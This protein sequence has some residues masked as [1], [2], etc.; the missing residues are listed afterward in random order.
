MSEA[1]EKPA[2]QGGAEYGEAQIR[3]LEGIE[4]IRTRPAM[5][6][7]DTGTRGFHHLVYEVVDNSVDEAVN[8]H[9]SKISVKINADGSVTCRDDGRGIPVGP[10]KDVDN[11]PAVE[12]VLTHIHAGGKFD[13]DSGYKTGTGGLHG[14]GITA[15]NALSEWLTRCTS[16]C[17]SWHF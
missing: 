5:Y 1:S 3:A 13:R 14:V 6:I 11:K 2:P 16:G 15:V 9:A 10:M 7:G 17:R 12:V 8:K 4:G